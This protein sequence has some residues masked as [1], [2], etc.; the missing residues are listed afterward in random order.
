M[1][2]KV[3]GKM[4]DKNMQKLYSDITQMNPE[5]QDVQGLKM[6]I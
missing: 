5:K 4:K 6:I 2:L 1:I 3:V